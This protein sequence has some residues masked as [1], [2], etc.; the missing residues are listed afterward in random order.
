MAIIVSGY[1]DEIGSGILIAVVVAI[2][3]FGFACNVIPVKTKFYLIEDYTITKTP[4]RVVV[5]SNGMYEVFDNTDFFLNTDDFDIFLKV[6]YNSYRTPTYK[7]I[8]YKRK[9]E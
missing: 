3:G 5:E 1:F 7:G 9:K 8:V 6:K 2:F 4:I